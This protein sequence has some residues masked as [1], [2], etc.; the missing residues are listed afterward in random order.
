M[1]PVLFAI[2]AVF[3][4][5]LQSVIMEQKLAK[6]SPGALLVFFYFTMLPL[7]L[8]QVGYLKFT[9]KELIIPSSN[10]VLLVFFV[11]VIYF[12]A[13]FCYF[14]AYTSGGSLLTITTIVITFPVFASVIKYFCVKQPPNIYQVFGYFFAV[15][16]ILLV[17]KGSQVSGG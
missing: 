12:I 1:K 16:A 11:G 14:S 2:S 6:Y 15:I 13:D 3:L 7:A 10:I 5:S 8:L 17:T 9:D 4:Y